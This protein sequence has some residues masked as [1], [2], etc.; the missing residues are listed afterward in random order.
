MFRRVRCVVFG[1]VLFVSLFDD[2]RIRVCFVCKCARLFSCVEACLAV[3]RVCLVVNVYVFVCMCVR[4]CV[5]TCRCAC[6]GVHMRV[7]MSCA[8][9]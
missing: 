8:C 2:V 1:C 5:F 9:A 6:L 7:F 3:M 4:E